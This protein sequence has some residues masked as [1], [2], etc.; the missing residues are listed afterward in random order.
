EEAT[1]LTL[2]LQAAAETAPLGRSTHN[3]RFANPWW[4]AEIANASE[5]TRKARNRLARL[6]ARGVETEERASLERE[7]KCLASKS[8]ALV[9]R[10][11]AKWEQQWVAETMV[12]MLWRKVKMLLGKSAGAG[13]GTTPP[14]RRADSSYAV[15]VE[16]KRDVLQPFLL[17]A[18]QQEDPKQ[19]AEELASQV[20]HSI[21][22]SAS[23]SLDD[24]V[25]TTPRG[26]RASITHLHR[27]ESPIATTRPAQTGAK[28]TTDSNNAE[29]QQPAETR[30]RREAKGA[31]AWVQ[32]AGAEVAGDAAGAVPVQP[33]AP[34]PPFTPSAPT[35]LPWPVLHEEEV[36]SA[37]FAARPFAAAGPDNVPNVVIQH[38]WPTLRT[39]LVPLYAAILRTGFIPHSWRDAIAVVLKK[40]KKEDYSNTKAYRLITF[41]RCIAK[42]IES[43]VAKRLAYIAESFGLLPPEHAGGRRGRSAQDV[44]SCI[45]DSIRR[46][47]WTGNFV[48]G[49]ALDV[50]KAFPSVGVDKLVDNLCGM[51]FPPEVLTFVRA[52]MVGWSCW[53]QFEGTVS[54]PLAWESG[55]PQGSPLSPILFLLYNVDLIHLAKTPSSC[56]FGW[57]DD[58]NILAWG[59]QSPPRSLLPKPSSPPLKHGPTR[60]TPPSNPTKRR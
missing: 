12:E 36:W 45:V 19:S 34:P 60:T 52:F 2:A 24:P 37:I 23:S 21:L 40:P 6:K 1:H 20:S 35:S 50:A 3:P 15:S 28:T 59:R 32:R 7:V 53:L 54:K 42:G 11:K 31:K 29:I 39:R 14:L 33:D 47:F 18:V 41:E 55:L 5:E 58:V 30:E 57:I 9:R 26:R 49:I 44:V 4:T 56:G 25:L 13:E 46:Q 43:I 48:V 22:C 10:E 51:A 8:K 38:C 16:D 17:P 27:T